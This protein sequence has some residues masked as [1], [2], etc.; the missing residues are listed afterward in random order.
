MEF[1]HYLCFIT[2]GYVL[3]HEGR[4]GEGCG[5][6]HKREREKE[7]GKEHVGTGG[8]SACAVAG[9]TAAMAPGDDVSCC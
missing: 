3:G 2:H 7:T 8:N 5:K 4:D 1:P 9:S 6:G